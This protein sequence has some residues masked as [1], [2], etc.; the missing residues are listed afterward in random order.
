[1]Q[2]ILDE[3]RDIMPEELPYGL[4][5]MRDNQHHIDLVPGASLLNLL[6]YRLSPKESEILKARA[7]ANGTYLGEYE[8]MCST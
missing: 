8:F 4:P 6:H 7:A 2:P 1:M 3:F 5:P